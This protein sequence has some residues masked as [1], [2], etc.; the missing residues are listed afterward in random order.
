M[1]ALVA[2]AHAVFAPVM[3]DRYQRKLP[4]AQWME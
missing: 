3:P 4:A 1:P 2:E